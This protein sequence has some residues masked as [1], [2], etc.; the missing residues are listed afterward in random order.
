MLDG[1][2]VDGPDGAVVEPDE[3]VELTGK[4]LPDDADE[5]HLE[6][7]ADKDGFIRIPFKAFKSRIGRAKK[8][9]LQ[10]VFGTADRAAIVAQKE[11]YEKLVNDREKQR[12]AQLDEL[13]RE[14]EEKAAAIARAEKLE[15]A[16]KAQEEKQLIDEATHAVSK[17]AAKSF[18]DDYVDF[19]MSRYRKHLRSLTDEETE[20]LT[21]EDSEQWF[22]DEVKRHKAMAR[23]ADKEEKAEKVDPKKK[24]PI[25]NGT[26]GGNDR[27]AK[28]ASGKTIKEMTKEEIK[29]HY[30][31]SW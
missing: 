15:K 31:V 3:E 11:E 17:L 28:A 19:A 16:L 29:A 13:T 1:H 2:A 26:G 10:A 24:V 4:V 14:K 27:P 23:P 20:A 25:T 9:E 8:A 21:E 18:A 30:G 7:Y 5:E 22:A 12:K 6:K